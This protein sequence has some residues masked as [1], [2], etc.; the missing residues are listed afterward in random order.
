MAA[1]VHGFPSTVDALQFE[2]AWQHPTRSLAVR[3]AAAALGAALLRRG[4]RG[5][6][7]LAFAMLA[8]PKWRSM[9]LQV[10][11]LSTKYAGAAGKT[12]PPHVAVCVAPVDDL[13]CYSGGGAASHAE[14][15]NDDDDDNSEEDDGDSSSDDR[16]DC[17]G[18]SGVQTQLGAGGCGE[19]LSA[20]GKADPSAQLLKPRVRAPRPP[21]A[22]T[23]PEPD[24]QGERD[25]MGGSAGAQPLPA[26]AP[27]G[28][29][30]PLG[31]GVRQRRRRPQAAPLAAPGADDTLLVAVCGAQ[32]WC[33]PAVPVEA[34]SQ[35]SPLSLSLHLLQPPSAGTCT[36]NPPPPPPLLPPP[37]GATMTAGRSSDAA[38]SPCSPP[39]LRCLD[40]LKVA[41]LRQQPASA[42]GRPERVDLDSPPLSPLSPCSPSI[43]APMMPVAHSQNNTRRP[44]TPSFVSDSGNSG[45]AWSLFRP[46]QLGGQVSRATPM[47]SGR[48]VHEALHVTPLKLAAAADWPF[49]AAP[50][51]LIVLS[52]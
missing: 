41:G 45:T 32:T 19:P 26:Q 7:A 14:H 1:V 10:Q 21:R 29:R 13:P 30:E 44:L 46:L 50:C 4:A 51:Q 40:A 43:A 3:G 33:H 9:P 42:R 27:S 15:D 49:P 28:A 35:A 2:W 34:S 39:L 52:P 31:A 16:E 37:M 12:P 48:A 38:A 23:E 8:L 47:L 22:A 17:V 36:W 5:K 25:T 6:L 24:T 18:D 20:V 11:F